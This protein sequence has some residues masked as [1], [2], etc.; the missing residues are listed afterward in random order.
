MA[1]AAPDSNDTKKNKEI[2]ESRPRRTGIAGILEPAILTWRL[3]W[4]SRVDS[5]PK[6]IPLGA[7]AYFLSPIDIIPELAF[8]PIGV[9]D[10]V[11]LLILALNAFIAVCPPDIVADI[12]QRIASGGRS[13]Q[14]EVVDG[15]ATVTDEPPMD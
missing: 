5:L 10:D 13:S 15:T 12:R 2:A 3:F 14:G 4:D 6:L 9:I 7:I 11:G 8:G 1:S